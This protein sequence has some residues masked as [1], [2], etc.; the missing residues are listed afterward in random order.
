VLADIVMEG[1]ASGFGHGRVHLW[2]DAGRLL[3]TATQSFTCRRRA[4]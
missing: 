4:D 3:A 1:I 2:D